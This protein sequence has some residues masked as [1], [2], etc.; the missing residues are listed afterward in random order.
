[1]L[2]LAKDLKVSNAGIDD[3]KFHDLRHTAA[4][5][6]AISGVTEKNS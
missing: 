1:M 6:L 4:S 2:I 3:F 5:Y